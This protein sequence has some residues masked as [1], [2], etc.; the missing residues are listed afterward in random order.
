MKINKE[1]TTKQKRFQKISEKQ[2][3]KQLKKNEKISQN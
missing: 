1:L 2:W 3:K